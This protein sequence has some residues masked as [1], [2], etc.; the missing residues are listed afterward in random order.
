MI[1]W[2]E[3]WLAKSKASV[4]TVT[5]DRRFLEK[6]CTRIL[7]LENGKLYS[8][9]GSYEAYLEARVLRDEQEKAAAQK[10]ENL[11]RHELEWVR[12][13]VQARGTKQKSRLDRFEQLRAQRTVLQN[14]QLDLDFASER[15]G[16][17]TLEWKNIAFGYTPERILFHDFSYACKKGDRLALVGPNGCGKPT[18]LNLLH[19]DLK[20]LEGA[21]E[22]GSTVRLGYFRQMSDPADEDV[23]VIDYIRKYANEIQTAEGSVSASAFLERFFFDSSRQYLPLGRL[24]GGERRRLELVRVLMSAPNV[25]LMDEPGNDLDIETLEV[26]ED[27]LDQFPGIV[28]FVS[29]DRFFLDRA[30]TDLF[31]LQENGT[32]RRYTGGYSDL[33]AIKEDEQAV[34]METREEKPVQKEKK[35]SFSSKEKREL[36][37]IPGRLEKNEARKAEID[38]LLI[39]VTDYQEV[40]KLSDE[41]EALVKES[42]ALEE[43]WMELEE[44]REQVAQFFSKK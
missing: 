33:L 23:R 38:D 7:E 44:K 10:R 24:S 14:R 30:A 11:Y 40:A 13:G 9:P 43:R 22:F 29:H 17:K 25:L 19:G 36:E 42:E 1:E 41:R 5:H 20:P 4:I 32:F 16:K 3:K 6:A 35:P 28:I 18:F 26:L 39:S 31:E 21:F 27:Y 15:L 8:H 2:L 34:R 12:A 37:E